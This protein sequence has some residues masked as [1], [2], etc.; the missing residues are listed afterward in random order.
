MTGTGPTGDGTRHPL[1]RLLSPIEPIPVRDPS[2]TTAQHG[3]DPLIEC[4]PGR[5]EPAWLRAGDWRLF[6]RVN[7]DFDAEPVDDVIHSFTA[8]DGRT[9][10]SYRAP[11]GRA[12]V[13]F[14]FADAYAAYSAERWAEHTAPLGLPPR[15]LD[16]FY[17]FKAAIP[18]GAQLAARRLLIRRQGRPAF[19]QWPYD[20]SIGALLRF[21]VRCALVAER[22]G[23]LRFRWFWPDGARAAVILT[24]DVESAAGLRNAVRIADLEQARDLR[25][26]FNIVASEYPIDWGIVAELRDRGFELGVHGVFHDRS[27]FS[28]REEFDRQLPALRQMAERLGADGFRSPATHRV[29]DWLG[30]LPVSYDCTMPMSDPYE[31]QPG[32]CCSPWPF[33]IGQVVELPYTIP[34]DHT[35]FTLLR[36]SKPDLWLA[37]LDR[38]VAG[39]GLAQCVSHPD[40]GYLGDPDKEALYV[41]FLDAVAARHDVWRAL[42]REVA[43]WWRERDAARGEPAAGQLGIARIDD[44]GTITLEPQVGQPRAASADSNPAMQ[45]LAAPGR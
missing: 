20:D 11:D 45:G 15:L 33:F 5:G 2:W 41:E 12:V 27:L 18:R 24:H 43:A 37:Q 44:S 32:G 30:E 28:S 36:Q 23:S 7:G 34:Q 13:P 16:V 21:Y 4:R 8:E 17:R 38:I 10:P 1:E 14:G 42:P 29:N 9:V 6:A 31:P 19:P 26:S 35:T 39:A 40:P 22:K 25:S 3:P